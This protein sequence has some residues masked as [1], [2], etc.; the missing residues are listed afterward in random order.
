MQM[1]VNGLEIKTGNSKLGEDTIIFNMGPAKYCP[2]KKFCKVREDCYALRDE[3]LYKG[4]LEYRM[5]QCQYWVRN[6][7]S[8]IIQDFAALWEKYPEVMSKVRYF[9][10]NESGDFWSQHCVEKLNRLAVFLKVHYGLI[11]YG[12]TA[13]KDLKFGKHDHYLVKGSGYDIGNNG[14]TMVIN[15]IDELLPGWCLCPEDC[16][17]CVL[18]KRKNNVNV[19]FLNHVTKMK[20]VNKVQYTIFREQRQ[21]G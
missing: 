7:G 12:Y 4:V 6:R 9:R 19:A 11:T 1:K 13:R 2:A 3:K 18:C 17:D 8:V 10:F 5:R 15:H 20:R 16:T 21:E 14:Q